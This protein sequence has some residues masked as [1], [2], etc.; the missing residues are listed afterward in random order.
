MIQLSTES[1]NDILKCCD[2]K[3]LKLVAIRDNDGRLAFIVEQTI[4]G[5]LVRYSF[6]EFPFEII[7]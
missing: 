2:G 1:Y 7:G 4:K 3:D 6:I 5:E